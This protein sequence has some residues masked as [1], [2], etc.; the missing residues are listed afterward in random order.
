[1]SVTDEWI[2]FE[3]EVGEAEQD[4]LVAQLIAPPLTGAQCEAG[5]V[6]TYVL[7]AND[8][9]SLRARI[10]ALAPGR[11]AVR[12]FAGHDYENAWREAW[13]PFRIGRVC[14]VAPFH[15]PRLRADDVRLELEPGGAFGTGRHAT[16]RTSLL[17]LQRYVRAGDRLLDAGCGSGILGVA[18]ALLGAAAVLGI[19]NDPNAE[20][21]ARELAARNGVADR[22]RFPLGDLADLPAEVPFDGLVANLYYDLIQRHAR[23]LLARVPVGGYAVFGG[24]RRD[25]RERTRDL[26]RSAGLAIE[27]EAR[28]G[29][30]CAFA[31]RRER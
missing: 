28:R 23:G 19:D 12:R 29:R 15:T 31:G 6:R 20:A 16:T 1:M 17:G 4:E 10:D 25:E 21:F 8:S 26:L 18:G 11:V 5:L 9:L 24:C 30:W 3:I 27:W 7:A 2:E 13:H 22:C 14:I